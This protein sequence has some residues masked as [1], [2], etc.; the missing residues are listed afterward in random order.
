[1]NETERIYN[2]VKLEFTGLTLE[3]FDIRGYKADK[4]LQVKVEGELSPK[5]YGK[6]YYD[7]DRDVVVYM[8]LPLNYFVAA[9]RSLRLLFKF[10][11]PE[12]LFGIQRKE[13]V[14]MRQK[15]Y[16]DGYAKGKARSVDH[17]NIADMRALVDIENSNPFMAPEVQLK[18]FKS[19]L[20]SILDVS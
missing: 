6:S 18:L 19:K 12:W 13:W 14:K 2:G 5:W 16:W 17:M 20:R 11:I 15:F 4:F 1:M 7:F 9:F 8:P 10:I 3:D